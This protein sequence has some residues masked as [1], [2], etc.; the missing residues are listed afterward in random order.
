M[1]ISNK[2]IGFS[3]K[4]SWIRLMFEKGA[5]LKAEFG[6]ENIFDFSLGNP[7]IPPPAELSATLLR[8]AAE[9]NAGQHA[10]MPNAGYPKVRQS[11]AQKVS[12]EQ[13]VEVGFENIIMT[14]GAAGGLNVIM[15]SLLNPGDEVIILAPYFVEY[16]FYIDNHGGVPVIVA[17]AED[18]SLDISAISRALTP[19]T[20]AIIVN[21]PNNPSGQIYSEKSLAQ[22][23]EALK[24]AEKKFGAPVY[25]VSDEPYR[26]IVYDGLE[27][28]SIFN[29][30]ANSLVVTSF[31]KDLS[32]PGERIGF[33]A[34]HPEVQDR[35]Q[36]LEVMILANRILGFVNAPAL[37]QR[38]VG[39]MAPASIDAGVYAVRRQMFCDI[40]SQCGYEF[41]A[42]KGAFYVFP[43]SP[44][45]SDV[46]FVDILQQNKILAVPGTGFGTPGYF[47]LAFCVENSVIQRSS[48]AFRR[49]MDTARNKV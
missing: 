20:K 19:K 17:T 18:F 45:E 3:K 21:S 15:K 38:V 41:V 23:A 4:S 16:V 35:L 49:A 37:M 8:L 14:C 13:G 10:Y 25:I 27:V 47:R 22:L 31:S 12:G 9:K 32:I 43:K 28:P 33:I 24:Q 40:L 2:M 44:L 30:Y 29:A 11:V 6:A 5:K 26:K 36:L 39:E 34:V 46:E 7:D 42:P 48:D 1:T